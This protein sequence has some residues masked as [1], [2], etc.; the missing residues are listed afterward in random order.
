MTKLIARLRR[1]EE[2]AM[3]PVSAGPLVI[4]EDVPDLESARMQAQRQGRGVVV[5]SL[6]DAN[7]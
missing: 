4:M 1:L 5:V 7:L 2:A 6:L 3:P